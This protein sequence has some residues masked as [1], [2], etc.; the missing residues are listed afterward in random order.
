MGRRWAKLKHIYAGEVH[1][2]RILKESLVEEV[3]VLFE[4]LLREVRRRAEA[5]K[6]K[7]GAK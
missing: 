7:G 5:D 3:P 1:G 4:D 6:M 2:L